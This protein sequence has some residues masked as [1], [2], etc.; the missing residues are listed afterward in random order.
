MQLK[1]LWML[2]TRKFKLIFAIFLLAGGLLISCKKK[3]VEEPDAVFNKKELLINLADNVIMPAM[4][5]FQSSIVA[6]EIELTSLENTPTLGQFDNFKNA[7]KSAYLSWQHIKIFDFGPIKNAGFKSATATYPCDSVKIINN[8]QS[9]AYNLSSIENIDA[10]GLTSM[11]YLLYQNNALADY[12]S[13][14]NY[15]LYVRAVVDKLLN[16]T[17]QVKSAWDAYRAT[18]VESD[19]TAST[20]AFSLLVNEFTRDFELAKNA[21]LGIPIGKQS[22]GILRPE[23]LEVRRSDFSLALLKE[24]VV[25]LK[26]TYLGASGKGFDDYLIFL[27]KTSLN[28]SIVGNFDQS[29]N[30]LAAIS[31]DFETAMTTNFSDLN[32]VYLIMQNQVVNIK[33]DMPSAFGVLITYQD[34]DG[35]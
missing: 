26:N 3:K 10:I 34:N 32:N 1:T 33:T 9:G 35:D 11:D 17:N 15:R 19:G 22:L 16:E 24:S 13:T 29:I 30:G 21:K 5:S 8:I 28:Q 18:F 2:N 31:T 12:Q 7:W 20:S 27:E 6:L 25:A 14:T 23:Y 4:S